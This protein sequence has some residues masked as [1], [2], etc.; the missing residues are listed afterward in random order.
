MLFLYYAMGGGLGHLVRARAFLYSHGLARDAVVLTASE[1]AGDSRLTRGLEIVCVPRELENDV[2]EFRGWLTHCI[3]DLNPDRVC[4]DS[5][6]CGIVGELCD[7]SPLSTIRTWHLARLLRWNEYARIIHGTPPRFAVTWRLEPL[8][9]EHEQFLAAHSD[10]IEDLALADV[11]EDRDGLEIPACPFW[12]VVHSGPAS[13]VGELVGYA[14]DMRDAE[15][16]TTRIVVAT[17]NPP[18]T[19][20]PGC[21]V[22]NVFPAS[23]LFPYAQRII[24][25]AGF[26]VMRQGAPFRDKHFVVPFPRR[27]DDQFA[28]AARSGS[29]MRRARH[30]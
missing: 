23:G 27:F 16:V 3:E 28:R 30:Q 14:V 24:S 26:N 1:Y 5:F 25:A 11:Y 20:P 4:V 7:F 19:L 18:D 13:E 10:V 22:L 2:D 6:P 15:R 8:H 9:D 17:P 12:L 29:M 21:A